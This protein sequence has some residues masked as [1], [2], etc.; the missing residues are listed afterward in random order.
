MNATLLFV[1]PDPFFRSIYERLFRAEGFDVVCA[2]HGERVVDLVKQVQPRAILMALALPRKDGFEVMEELKSV[3]E[4]Q[5]IPLFVFSR[6]GSRD[7]VERCFENGVC[8]YLIKGHQHP[9]EVVAC[10]KKYL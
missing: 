8:E 9:E 7:V 4:C 6:V 10:I 2:A 3:P 5:S 1:E